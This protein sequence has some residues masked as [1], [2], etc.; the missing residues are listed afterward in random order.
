LDDFAW[1]CANANLEVHPARE[2]LPNFYGLYDIH[3]NV[4]EWTHDY[5]H[6]TPTNP[7]GLVTLAQAN[8]VD[9]AGDGSLVSTYRNTKGGNYFSE[10]RIARIATYGQKPAA[11]GSLGAG[12]RLVRSIITPV[13]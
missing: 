6:P 3:G 10:P 7:L 8:S 13:Q 4:V 2:K 9:L 12:G 11:S 5:I 1:Y